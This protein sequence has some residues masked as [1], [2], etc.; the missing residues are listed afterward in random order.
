MQNMGLY[1]WIE[2]TPILRGRMY[3]VQKTEMVKRVE[4]MSRITI[5]NCQN[6]VEVKSLD[7]LSLQAEVSLLFSANPHL[8]LRV[9]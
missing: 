9:R 3:P 2:Q 4:A 5:L 1:S 8:A 7:L 6:M